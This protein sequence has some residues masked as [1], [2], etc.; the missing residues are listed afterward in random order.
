MRFVA[1]Q[2]FTTRWQ[3]VIMHI[4]DLT[5]GIGVSAGNH[6]GFRAV[7]YVG[8][9]KLIATSNVQLPPAN[10]QANTVGKMAAAGAVDDA[11]TQ[12]YQLE[13]IPPLVRREQL[14]LA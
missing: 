13:A 14:L 3:V 5:R 9:R 11:R 6:H 12:N 2:V 1:T 10:R 4:V 8:Q 7:F